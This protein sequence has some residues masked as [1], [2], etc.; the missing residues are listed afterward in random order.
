MSL[1]KEFE[2]DIQRINALFVVSSPQ[3][4]MEKVRHS[5]DLCKIKEEIRQIKNVLKPLR[6]QTPLCNL[7]QTFFK[8]LLR[9]Q[10]EVFQIESEFKRIS[11][12][13]RNPSCYSHGSCRDMT[14]EQSAWS[15]NNEF[16]TNLIN[17]NKE[18]E[19]IRQNCINNLKERLRELS[20]KIFILQ[21]YK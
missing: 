21:D 8:V 5:H 14:E 16:T 7:D 12:S 6:R 15:L 13:F 9:L 17:R 3:F 2:D 20:V 10:K 1:S 18:K 4:S 19:V 11:Y